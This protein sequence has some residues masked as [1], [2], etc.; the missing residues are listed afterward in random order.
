[1]GI[2]RPDSTGFGLTRA[3]KQQA[4]V[5]FVMLQ[6]G[7]ASRGVGKAIGTLRSKRKEKNVGGTLASGIS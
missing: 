2:V 6:N 3:A 5:S 1:M 7:V 4:V